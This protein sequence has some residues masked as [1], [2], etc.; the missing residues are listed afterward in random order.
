MDLVEMVAIATIIS[1]GAAAIGI[2][3][4]AIK[5]KRQTK[6][7]SANLSLEL[8]KRVRE[9]DFADIVDQIFDDKSNECD[10][11]TLERF[12]NHFDMIAKFHEERLIDVAHIT[13]IYGGLLRKIKNDTHIQ[14]I[15]KKDEKL[16]QPLIRL[17]NKI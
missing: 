2:I 14:S 4:T 13:Q 6:I 3:I 1:G 17:Y 10:P 11:V 5:T 9:K 16:F 15:I 12:L 8:I 7:D